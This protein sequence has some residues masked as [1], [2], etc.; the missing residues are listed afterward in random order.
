MFLC[1]MKKITFI[2]E[3][4]YNVY[5]Q[6]ESLICLDLMIKNMKIPIKMYFNWWT[7]TKLVCTRY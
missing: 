2:K 1:I 3:F 7:G 4:C 6:Y 5:N